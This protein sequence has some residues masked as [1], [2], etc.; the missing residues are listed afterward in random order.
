[1]Q[2]LVTIYFNDENS[3]THGVQEH[4]SNFLRDGWRIA[5][6]VPLGSSV[7]SGGN[8]YHPEEGK[9]KGWLAV[10]LEKLAQ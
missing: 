5:T 2:K 9:V 1:M 10:L 6:M 7:G 4:L 3:A 8:E